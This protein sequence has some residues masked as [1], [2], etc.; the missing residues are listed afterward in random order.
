LRRHHQRRPGGIFPFGSASTSTV[1]RVRTPS[2]S[3]RTRW[4]AVVRSSSVIS[5]MPSPAA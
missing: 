4:T 5:V 3:K 2:V 1:I